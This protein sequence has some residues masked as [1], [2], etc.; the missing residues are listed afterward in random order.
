VFPVQDVYSVKEGDLYINQESLTGILCPEVLGI[1]LG[2]YRDQN[3]N[4]I[5]TFGNTL[6]LGFG[7]HRDQ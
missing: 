3:S 1:D 4:L 2:G 6:I 5:L 7:H